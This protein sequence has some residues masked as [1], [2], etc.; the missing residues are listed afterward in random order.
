MFDAAGG[1]PEPSTSVLTT[2]PESVVTA[3]SSADAALSASAPA[4]TDASAAC[5][6]FA[7]RIAAEASVAA[8][9]EA[10]K[11]AAAEDGATQTASGLVVKTLVEGSGD[12]PVAAN[13]VKVHYEGTLDDGTVFDSSI[14]RGEPIEFPLTGVIK[15]WTEGLQLMK[16]GG[17]AKLTIPQ[18]LA[19]GEGGSGPIPPKATLI[20]EVELIEVK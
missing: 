4:A 13:T 2:R 10:L 6:C 16:P 18:E 17:K 20:F 19:Y 5:A 14:A 1:S 9:A 7:C 8:G 11:A 15:G 12:P 3:P